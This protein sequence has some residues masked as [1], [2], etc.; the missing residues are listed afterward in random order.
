MFLQKF[1]FSPNFRFCPKISIFTKSSIF[2]QNFHFHQKFPFSSKSSIFIK[3]FDFHQ[4]F[5]HKKLTRTYQ[6]WRILMFYF[7]LLSL[8]F[9]KN[10]Q[11]FRDFAG[12]SGHELRSN[13]A[14]QWLS[15]Q[16]N[17]DNG[18]YILGFFVQNERKFKKHKFCNL[19]EQI[20]EKVVLYS[21]KW[22]NLE[23]KF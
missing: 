20:M 23:K 16:K 7:F 15:P 4:N 8:N 10:L 21:E 2:H 1:D 12:Q 3:K 6:G 18:I 11:Y 9:S 19:N 17:L 13:S 14:Q 5:W 22:K